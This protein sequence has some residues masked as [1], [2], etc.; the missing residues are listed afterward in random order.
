M[1]WLPKKE[2]DNNVSISN[3]HSINSTYPHNNDA[4]TDN[5]DHHQ[6]SANNPTHTCVHLA[7]HSTAPPC[8]NSEFFDYKSKLNEI[9]DTI[10]MMMTEWLTATTVN[11]DDQHNN[12]CNTDDCNND[13]SSK[14]DRD[15]D[16]CNMDKRDNEDRHNDDRIQQKDSSHKARTPRVPPPIHGLYQLNMDTSNAP[17]D[18]V[19]CHHLAADNMPKVGMHLTTLNPAPPCHDDEFDYKLTLKEI[20]DAINMMKQSWP[21]EWNTTQTSLQNWPCPN[22]TTTYLD[23]PVDTLHPVTEA[24]FFSTATNPAITPN[25]LSQWNKFCT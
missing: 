5:D 16:K 11:D 2:T 21:M 22:N 23:N 25:V 24:E 10:N 1:V 8:H 13:N 19:D 20:D 3:T 9:D 15:N 14:K 17:I 6:L 4:S 7:T 12:D 18:D